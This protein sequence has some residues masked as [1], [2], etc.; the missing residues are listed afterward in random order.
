MNLFLKYLQALEFLAEF[1]NADWK[2]FQKKKGGG[3]NWVFHLQKIPATNQAVRNPVNPLM[4]HTRK[5]SSEVRV[6][7]S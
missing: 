7:N 2:F 4:G 5:T 6:V 3:G 1:R